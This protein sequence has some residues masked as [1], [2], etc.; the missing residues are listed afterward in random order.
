MKI[1]KLSIDSESRESQKDTDN[2]DRAK[3]KKFVIRAVSFSKEYCRKD[4][5]DWQDDREKLDML[6]ITVGDWIR[7]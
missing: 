2:T 7:L 3:W 5:H 1:H 4:K 6:N